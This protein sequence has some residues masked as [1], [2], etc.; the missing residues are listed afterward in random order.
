ML[1]ALFV[2]FG[3]FVVAEAV[4]VDVFFFFIVLAGD[5]PA[6]PCDAVEFAALLEAAS[7]T[8]AALA[9]LAT[10]VRSSV[11]GRTCC[12]SF[13]FFLMA[14]FAVSVAS[15]TLATSFSFSCEMDAIVC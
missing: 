6:P 8:A 9:R 1:L 12:W 15:I 10:V 13:L 7:L 5:T 14:W 4:P 3:F 2:F 11:D